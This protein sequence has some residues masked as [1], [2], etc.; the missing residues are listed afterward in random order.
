MLVYSFKHN[1]E[2][3]AVETGLE[4]IENELEAI[5][6]FVGGHLESLFIS[7]NLTAIMNEEGKLLDLYPVAG[8]V[9]EEV[10]ED[11]QDVIFGD[12]FI[13]RVKDSDFTDIIPDEDIPIIKSRLR[14]VLVKIDNTIFFDDY[15]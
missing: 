9:I 13:C 14:P 4:N 10:N 8:L 7:D 15:Q 11:Y 2:T 6:K 5:Q 1:K 3:N 12:M